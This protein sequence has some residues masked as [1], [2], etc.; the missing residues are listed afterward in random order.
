[1]FLLVAG[2]SLIADYTFAKY[3][4]L[5]AS[6][7][8]CTSS[9]CTRRCTKALGEKNPEVDLIVYLRAATGL[10]MQRIA[11]R[12]RPYECNMESDYIDRLNRA[13][14]DFFGRPYD[15][16]PVLVVDTNSLASSRTRNTSSTSKHDPARET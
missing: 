1:M 14:E 7:S 5:P 11:S 3:L 15:G 13:Y 8:R 2:K 16:A 6:I 12:D 4:L 9:R 10:L